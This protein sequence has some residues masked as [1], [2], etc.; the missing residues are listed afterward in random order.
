MTQKP[1]I[2]FAIIAPLGTD[3]DL[4]QEVFSTQIFTHEYELE[5][6]KFTNLLKRFPNNLDVSYNTK[7][8][9]YEKYI[10]AGNQ[11]VEKTSRKDILALGAVA[12]A[13]EISQKRTGTANKC[14]FFRQIKRPQ[15]IDFLKQVYKDR[16]KFIGCYTPKNVRIEKIVNELRENSRGVGEDKL[17][18]KALT[19]I[20][21]DENE[22]NIEGGQRFL[23]CYPL[24]DFIVDCSSRESIKGSI[25]RL[26][27][28]FFGY[29]Y[30]SPSID[31]YGM[32]IASLVAARSTDLS[33]QV[34][35]AIMSEEKI[36]IS[37]GCNEVPKSFGG[38]YWDQDKDDKRDF[39]KGYDS[40]AKVKSDIIRDILTRLQ[41]GWLKEEF[42]QKPADE[43][44]KEALDKDGPLRDAM[45][46]GLIEFGRMVHAE[47]NAI[48]DAARIGRS[49]KNSTLYCT[50]MPCH[51]CAKHIVASGIKRVV[52]LQ[53]YH[54]SL[55]EE[56][57]PDSISIDDERSKKVSFEPFKG[58]TPNSYQQIFQ[59]N[60]KRKD[61]A[62]KVLDWNARQSIPIFVQSTLST[63]E[64]AEAQAVKDL[65]EIIAAKS[66]S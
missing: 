52:Y 31:E 53:P 66:L 18:S 6:I 47:M 64:P 9:R 59:K 27:E 50:T 45:V 43:M 13:F 55:V 39:Q 32:S 23:D 40:N 57:Y 20:D 19:L 51:L 16:I 2:N 26:L 30:I 21:I 3:L 46:D 17:R 15:E 42:Q 48:T 38:T 62:G 44:V 36:I 63:F 22:K 35:S 49:L 5:S 10:T 60:Y 41:S 14:R 28:A 11:I 54:K 58:V 56:L 12:T 1:D 33:R 25:K 65:A 37:L 29:H 8:E 7:F 61:D 4:L 34:G 24:S